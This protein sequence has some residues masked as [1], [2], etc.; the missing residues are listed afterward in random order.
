MRIEFDPRDRSSIRGA[1]EKRS[2]DA[3][4]YLLALGCPAEIAE[5][6]GMTYDDAQAAMRNMAARGVRVIDGAAF[7]SA[8][9][10]RRE[11]PINRDHVNQAKA[12]HYA[13]VIADDQRALDESNRARAAELDKKIAADNAAV[14]RQEESDAEIRRK[15]AHLAGRLVR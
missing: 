5:L 8:P 15:M 9:S 3:V 13:R 7:R 4:A 14:A 10:T 1:V 12:A 11:P 6:A 2:G